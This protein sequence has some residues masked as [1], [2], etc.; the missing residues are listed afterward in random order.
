ML[1]IADALHIAG[2]RYHCQLQNPHQDRVC[3]SKKHME[4]VAVM[5]AMLEEEEGLDADAAS[6]GAARSDDASPAEA[7]G[8]DGEGDPSRG[9]QRQQQQ[10]GERRGKKKKR[11]RNQRGGGGDDGCGAAEDSDAYDAQQADAAIDPL[12]AELEALG[13]AGRNSDSERSSAQP[14]L[15]DEA[16]VAGDAEGSDGS[17]LDT[18]AMLERLVGS[19]SQPLADK[20]DGEVSSAQASLSAG[21]TASVS[22]G[23]SEDLTNG[24]QQAELSRDSTAPAGSAKPRRAKANGQAAPASTANTADA[25][26]DRSKPLARAEPGGKPMTKRQMRK[27]KGAQSAQAAE[28]PRLACGVCGAE[29]DSRTLLFKHIAS[30]GHALLKT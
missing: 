5:R 8:E 9:Q 3:R 10:H 7:D 13:L 28:V 1:A 4:A 23:L 12:A 2:A 25:G 17:G 30:S 20:A 11:K 21:L 29:F 24:S 22:N 14:E 27:Q 19:R 16:G 15:D 18:D 6:G 26:V